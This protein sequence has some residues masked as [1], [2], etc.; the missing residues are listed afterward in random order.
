MGIIEWIAGAFILAGV[1]FYGRKKIWGPLCSVIG[2]FMWLG[3][4]L[5]NHMWSLAFLNAILFVTNSYN[6]AAWWSGAKHI[7]LDEK[8]NGD[9]EGF[10]KRKKEI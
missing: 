10:F 2:C 3:I 5:T 9:G 4:G 1:W 6:L 8:G 7:E